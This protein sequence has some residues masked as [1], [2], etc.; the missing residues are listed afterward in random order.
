VLGLYEEW[1][2]NKVKGAWS[3]ARSTRSGIDAL[4][5]FAQYHNLKKFIITL[6]AAVPDSLR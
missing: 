4:S 1:T 2:S 6:F 5:V 3:I